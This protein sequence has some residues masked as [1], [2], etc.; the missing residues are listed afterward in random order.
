MIRRQM[1]AFSSLSI[2]S[3]FMQSESIDCTCGR[4][5]SLFG[6]RLSTSSSMLRIFCSGPCAATR[7]GSAVRGGGRRRRRRSARA[8]LGELRLALAEQLVEGGEE[9]LEE[10]PVLRRVDDLDRVAHL[11]DERL[12]LLERD[13]G[14]HQLEARLELPVISMAPPVEWN[15]RNERVRGECARRVRALAQVPGRSTGTCGGER[16]IDPTPG[17]NRDR[18]PGPTCAGGAVR[19]ARVVPRGPERV[20]VPEARRRCRRPVRWCR[21]SRRP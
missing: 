6:S 18:I 12:A 19:V 16:L 4:S 7:G 5:V 21:P 10:V 9:V 20:R 17:V 1:T 14:R 2:S 8:H 15:G 13:V 3:S 11:G